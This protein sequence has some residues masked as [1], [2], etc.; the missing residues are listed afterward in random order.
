MSDNILPEGKYVMRA[1]G[2]ALKKSGNGNTYLVMSF[3][4]TQGPY[5]GHSAFKSFHFTDKALERTV[6]DL[7]LCGWTGDDPSEINSE[8][9]CGCDTNE[10]RCVIEHESYDR[11]GEQR[12]AVKVKWIN[13]M[14]SGLKSNVNASDAAAFGASMKGRIAA[15]KAKAAASGASGA[16]PAPA[17][18]ARP[19]STPQQ[20]ANARQT[21]PRPAPTNVQGMGGSQAFGDDD[22]PFDVAP[23]SF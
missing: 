6:E 16:R 11:D 10:V 2:A 13:G 19:V 3:D 22:I 5:A 9:L 1:T 7:Q 20:P 12:I 17:Q 18:H 8:N 23:E 4:V 21:A 14:D 15:L